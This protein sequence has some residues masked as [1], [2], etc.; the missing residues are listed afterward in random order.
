MNKFSSLMAVAAL[1]LSAGWMA[2]AHAQSQVR[3]E[4]TNNEYNECDAR[5]S[6][7]RLVQQLS[8]ARCTLEDTWGF[9]Q[10]TQRIWVARGCRAVF[11][12]VRNSSGS[13]SSSSTKNIAAAAVIGAVAGAV[14]M[15][16]VD[17]NKENKRNQNYSTNAPG[18]VP[19]SG[20]YRTDA[21]GYVQPSDETFDSR[22]QY[23]QNGEPN[24]DTHGNYV[25]CHGIGCAVDDPDSDD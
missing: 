19:P 18:Y 23:D 14:I 25:G 11:E 17:K 16:Q 3:C 20:Y 5:W 13:S 4:S 15:N 21:P 1:L 7:A 8:R 9:N 12:P 2:P 22:P 6:S 10:R 24:F